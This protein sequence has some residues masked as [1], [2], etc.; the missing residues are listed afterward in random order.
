MEHEIGNGGY[1]FGV[2]PTEHSARVMCSK[3]YLVLHI[4]YLAESRRIQ[5]RIRKFV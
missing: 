4:T 5:L 1:D 3:F 2:R